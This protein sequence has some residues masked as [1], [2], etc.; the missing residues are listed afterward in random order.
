MKAIQTLFS[1]LEKGECIKRNSNTFYSMI[2]S[3][4]SQIRRLLSEKTLYEDDF[5][6]AKDLYRQRMTG[7]L[8]QCK[9]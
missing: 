6:K 7:L 5:Q 3:I 9:L 8:L 4:N 2:Q 1:W